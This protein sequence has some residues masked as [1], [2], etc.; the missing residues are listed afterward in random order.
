MKS[1]NHQ[2]AAV[3]PVHAR[4]VKQKLTF[5]MI[6]T[7]M[8]TA[9]AIHAPRVKYIAMTMVTATHVKLTLNLLMPLEV[10][11]QRLSL[12]VIITVMK[13]VSAMPVTKM[14]LTVTQMAPVTHV[15]MTMI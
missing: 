5:I 4:V 10:K 2:D 15:L 11:L 9:A 8:K 7:V 3:I 6:S 13:T 1:Q 12:R 14:K